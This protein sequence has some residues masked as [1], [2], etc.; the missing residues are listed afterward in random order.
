MLS[1][2]KDAEVLKNL[3]IC[4][5]RMNISKIK[6]YL[7][8]I[9]LAFLLIAF[10]WQCLEERLTEDKYVG[11]IYEM[12]QKLQS[13]WMGVHD[14]ALHSDRYKGSEVVYVNYDSL[15]RS[16]KDWN[17]LQEEFKQLN[18]QVSFSFKARVILY[19]IGSYLVIIA[20]CKE[21]KDAELRR[22]KEG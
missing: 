6:L 9:G 14:E 12:E 2:L 8:P 4:I 13:I 11:Y 18:H 5:K 17:R 1:C 19:L 16:M 21:K 22:E 7:E 15:N 20:K 3:Y 10:G